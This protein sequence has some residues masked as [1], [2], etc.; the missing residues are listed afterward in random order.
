MIRKPIDAYEPAIGDTIIWT[1]WFTTWYGIVHA[2]DIRTH[3]L[4]II[5]EGT[6]YLL[7]ALDDYE[8]ESNTYQINL[9]KIRKSR[10]GTWTAIQHDYKEHVSVWHI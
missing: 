2:Y 7:A 5:F 4:Y 10:R 9:S 6:P 1:K 8:Y 3:T